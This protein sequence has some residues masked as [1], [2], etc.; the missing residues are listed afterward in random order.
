MSY[1]NNP[2]LLCDQ[3]FRH[4]CENCQTRTVRQNGCRKDGTPIYRRK[5]EGCYKIQQGWSSESS[6]GQGSGAQQRWKKLS[7]KLRQ[8]VGECQFCSFVPVDICQL[9]VDHIDGNHSN[10]E[11]TNLQVLCANCH[12][13]KT[14]LSGDH[15]S[16]RNKNNGKS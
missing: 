15:V 2:P 9:Q 16:R 13:L 12:A 6:R 7:K 5:C 4:V 1:S 14:K 3:C 10:N 11:R 8:E